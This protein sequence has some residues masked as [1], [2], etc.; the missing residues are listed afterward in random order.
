MKDESE[1]E[2]N[3][4]L[5]GEARTE[6]CE[7][8]SVEFS[9]G[10]NLISYRF[11]LRDFSSQGF[12]IIIRKDSKVLEYVKQG[13]V[14]NMQYHPYESADNPVPHRT[15]IKHISQPDPGKHKD[16]MLVGLLILE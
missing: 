6:S 12:G 4:N 16:H 14:I 1:Q 10:D 5:R 11:K 13:D 8:E 3:K 9:P 15:K 2:N 7:N